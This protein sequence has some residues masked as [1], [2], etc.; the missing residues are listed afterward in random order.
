MRRASASLVV[1]AALT[2]FCGSAMAQSG[3]GVVQTS[4]P[5]PDTRFDAVAGRGIND[6][7]RDR[8][9][10]ARQREQAEAADPERLALAERVA[11]LVEAGKC[12]E[13]R[14]MANEA[15]DRHM[16]L[17]VRQTCNAR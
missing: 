17:R 12:A 6:L 4:A 10:M 3:P 9:D 11:A 15:G 7:E 13:A 14:R 5:L 8:A 16:A 1:I 2:A